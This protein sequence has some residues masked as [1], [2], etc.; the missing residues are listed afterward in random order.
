MSS[1]RPDPNTT[2]SNARALERWERWE[3]WGVDWAGQP[4]IERDAEAH[5]AWCAKWA[6][7][8]PDGDPQR[9]RRAVAFRERNVCELELRVPLAIGE[10]G[11]CQVIFEESDDMVLVRVLV[12]VDEQ[13]D[14]FPREFM[15]CPVRVWLD[16]PL[17]NR[18]VVDLDSNE[19]LPLFSPE[20]LT[21]PTTADPTAP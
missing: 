15:N 2:N 4:I 17:E 13:A 9:V 3:R 21:Y 20:E 19:T 5:A 18:M 10:H 8:C 1:S 14:A 16:R 12:C 7:R 11:V 6:P